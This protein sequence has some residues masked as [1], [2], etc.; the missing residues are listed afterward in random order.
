[1]ICAT[2]PA[3]VSTLPIEKKLRKLSDSELF[4]QMRLV[5]RGER[6]MTIRIL[7]HLN[8][9]DRRKLYLKMGCSSLFDYCTR[10]LKYSSSAAGRRVQVARCIRRHPDLLELLRVRELSLSTLSLIAPILDRG[11]KA[12]ILSRV[13]GKSYREVERVAS[14]YRPPIALRDR[15]RPVRVRVSRP[16]GSVDPVDVDAAL[17]DRELRRLAPGEST[18][19]AG[20]NQ[21]EIEQKLFVQFLASEEL[22]EKFEEA[23]ALL[24]HRCGTG[25][26]AEVLEIVL[27]EFVERHSPEARLKRREARKAG[28]AA[29]RRRNPV[30]TAAAVGP[31]ATD[32]GPRVI[33]GGTQSPDRSTTVPPGRITPGAGS[34]KTTT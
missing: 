8:E 31:R 10:H 20:S 19:G 4:F 29:G 30:S 17:F 21:A 15:V 9:I 28:V 5:T 33:A 34:A 3:A 13:R 27:A 26:F 22:M 25:S 24:S 12:A 16:S 14:E 2:L 18:P 1:M 23:K 11:S 6:A 7:H 32:S